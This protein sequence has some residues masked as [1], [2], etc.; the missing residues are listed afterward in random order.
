[1]LKKSERNWLSIGHTLIGCIL[2][3]GGEYFSKGSIVSFNGFVALL[4]AITI[5]IELPTVAED[6]ARKQQKLSVAGQ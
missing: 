1:V 6:N 3:F 2:C 4:G 5:L